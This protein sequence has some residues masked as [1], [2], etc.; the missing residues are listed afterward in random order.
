M[1][2][3]TGEG[4]S[5]LEH[6]TLPGGNKLHMFLRTLLPSSSGCPQVQ[7]FL[8]YPDDRG[9]KFLQNVSSN[10]STVGITPDHIQ[11]SSF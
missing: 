10:N 5:V 3:I 7:N 11:S 6:H 4:P 1:G 8:N 9:S 2:S